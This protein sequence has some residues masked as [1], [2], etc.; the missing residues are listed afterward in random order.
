MNSL[1]WGPSSDEK[2]GRLRLRRPVTKLQGLSLGT[3]GQGNSSLVSSGECQETHRRSTENGRSWGGL[4]REGGQLHIGCTVA[5]KGW[6]GV[7]SETDFPVKE[8]I[9]MGKD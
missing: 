6:L 2:Q 4:L 9:N 3:R 7:P 1:G 8:N 5:R